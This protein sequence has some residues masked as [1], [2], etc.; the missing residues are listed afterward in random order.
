MRAAVRRAVAWLVAGVVLLGA[1]VGGS[2]SLSTDATVC[3]HPFSNGFPT[4]EYSIGS[5]SAVA[6]DSLGKPDG[7]SYYF[8]G[9]ARGS[10]GFGSIGVSGTYD[11]RR[12]NEGV[13]IERDQSG[14][15]RSVAT[16]CRANA[17][18]EDTWTVGGFTGSGTM[19]IT[20]D[21]SG[22]YSSGCD[23]PCGS[24][25]V[26]PFVPGAGHVSFDGGSAIHPPPGT[27]NL[28]FNRDEATAPIVLGDS[29]T[30]VF[31]IES[32]VPFGVQAQLFLQLVPGEEM[33]GPGQGEFDSS[34]VIDF[35][36]TAELVGI[37]VRDGGGDLVP[38]F[39]LETESGETY[40][41]APEPA[42]ALI[43]LAGGAVL[44]AVGRRSDA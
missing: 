9:V 12:A 19:S 16:P 42:E 44:L 20:F 39:T 29:V 7:I 3:R 17:R 18:F 34:G 41:V 13:F 43:L 6:D 21:V 23:L 37:E 11:A 33:P 27:V 15:A 38:D 40:G 31:P 2:A 22:F 36:Q 24:G 26:L 14:V 1:G 10:A 28:V 30:A 35:S 25:G 8:H 32:G 5:D 4:C